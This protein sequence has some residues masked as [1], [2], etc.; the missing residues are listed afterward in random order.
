MIAQNCA[1]L[2]QNC[3]ELRGVLDADDAA[4]F[5]LEHR[6]ARGAEVLEHLRREGR[7]DRLHAVA[8]HLRQRVDAEHRVEQVL[9]LIHI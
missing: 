9:S 4:Q 5:L 7:R 6:R 8:H 1:E 3:A 2:R